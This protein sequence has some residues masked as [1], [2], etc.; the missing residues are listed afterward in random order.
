MELKK[1]DQEAKKMVKMEILFT[2]LIK[3]RKTVR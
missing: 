2:I 3:E 1:N